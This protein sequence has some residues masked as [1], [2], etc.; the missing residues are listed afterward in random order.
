[1]AIRRFFYTPNIQFYNENYRWMVWP[2]SRINIKEKR[3]LRHSVCVKN[4]QFWVPSV[5]GRLCCVV[6]LLLS[7]WL[8]S[9]A[10]YQCLWY[11]VVYEISNSPRGVIH[12][13][14]EHWRGKK[15]KGGYPKL[16]QKLYLVKWYTN[17]EGDGV[18]KCPKIVHVVY[19]LSQAAV[20]HCI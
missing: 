8:M 17:Y 19:R 20:G 16:L 10:K 18:H 12:K 9:F 14:C 13:P 4:F 1:M 7:L 3:N 5:V 2:S 11:L 15:K 6:K